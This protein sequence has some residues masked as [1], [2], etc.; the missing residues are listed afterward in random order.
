M[1]ERKAERLRKG[2][3][4]LRVGWPSPSSMGEELSGG[5][6]PPSWPCCFMAQVQVSQAGAA[7]VAAQAELCPVCAHNEQHLTLPLILPFGSGIYLYSQTYLG[8]A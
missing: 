5:R 8:G 2:Y 1:M 3:M 4:L 7:A 6:Y